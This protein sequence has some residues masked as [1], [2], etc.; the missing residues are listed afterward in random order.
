MDRWS[1][2]LCGN[3]NFSVKSTREYI[4]QHYLVSSPSP[5]KWSKVIPIKLNVFKWRL[6]LDKLPT[7]LLREESWFLATF[8]LSA[9]WKP[10]SW[11]TFS[12]DAL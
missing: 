2:S 6:A 11:I 7:I 9:I 4:D 12:S 3:E 10:N 8:V 5:T 1:W